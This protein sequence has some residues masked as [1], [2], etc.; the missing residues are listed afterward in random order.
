MPRVS[1]YVRAA[2]PSPGA[3][4]GVVLCAGALLACATGHASAAPITYTEQA[5]ASGSLNGV[6]FT[7]AD[8]VLTMQADTGGVT[9]PYAGLFVNGG[10]ADVSVA[11]VGAATFGD[12]IAV[13]ANQGV[14]FGFTDMTLQADVLDTLGQS[15]APYDLTTAF[16]PASGTSG[17]ST[18][19]AFPTSLGS[20]V[21]SA[22]QSGATFAATMTAVPEPASLTLLA[23][24]LLGLGAIR[25]RRRAGGA[26][27]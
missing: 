10:T 26:E 14:G 7:N 12:S 20:F 2:R 15:F 23:A 17:Y 25:R 11:G 27:G 21:L 19:S 24:G 22:V 5:T 18:Q 3:A 6:A 13:F 4:L 1:R 16:G 8:V 9:S